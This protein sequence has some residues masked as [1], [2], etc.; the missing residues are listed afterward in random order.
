MRL[1]PSIAAAAASAAPGVFTTFIPPAFPLPPAWTWALTTTVP[2]R[3]K[4]AVAAWLGV[5]ATLPRGTGIPY[6]ERI[7]LDWNSC[8]FMYLS[9]RYRLLF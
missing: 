7:S 6:S 8:S 3:S 2:P 9:C 5:L 4:A 1:L